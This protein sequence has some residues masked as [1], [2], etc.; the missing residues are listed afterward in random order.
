MV[1]VK[2]TLDNPTQDY[3]IF[4]E[5][6]QSFALEIIKVAYSSSVKPQVGFRLEQAS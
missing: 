3:A 4:Q 1:T 5:T 2:S 6:F